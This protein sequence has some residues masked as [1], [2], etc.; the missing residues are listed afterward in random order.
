MSPRLRLVNSPIPN[1]R[2]YSSTA[3]PSEHFQ[4]LN[5][6]TERSLPDHTYR[7]SSNA[8]YSYKCPRNHYIQSPSSR[9]PRPHL[10]G[11][12][13]SHVLHSP[14]MYQYRQEQEYRPA[15]HRQLPSPA[16]ASSGPYYHDVPRTQRYE[17]EGLLVQRALSPPGAVFVPVERLRTPLATSQRRDPRR[18]STPAVP[19]PL[20][21]Q[22]V[23]LGPH[24]SPSRRPE[25]R[26]ALPPIYDPEIPWDL[27]ASSLGPY[28]R[29]TPHERIDPRPLYDDVP[30][31]VPVDTRRP[32][33]YYYNTRYDPGYV[34]TGPAREDHQ[35]VCGYLSSELIS[36]E[37]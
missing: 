36:I 29:R 5:I 6:D 24:D 4:S 8:Q 37:C 2:A 9:A 25:A 14:S 32:R 31:S 19:T 15:V 7:T 1:N 27:A 30:A 12:E 28:L 20:A 35:Q 17:Y 13:P 23:Q 11:E 26:P 18:F 10:E 34:D 33:P 3:G 22:P 16:A 21:L